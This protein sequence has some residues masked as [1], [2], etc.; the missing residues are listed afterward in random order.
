[1]I[2]L[3]S[4]A[5]FPQFIGEL[6]G[7]STRACYIQGNLDQHGPCCAGP[8]VLY[9]GL[10]VGASTVQRR[11][12]D[13]PLQVGIG[14]GGAAYFGHVHPFSPHLDA[15]HVGGE[16]GVCTNDTAIVSPS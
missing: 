14:A 2:L 10:G 5:P 13:H 7:F 8:K 9:S 3:T 6:A 15:H 12:P 16:V 1:M 4:I 11:L